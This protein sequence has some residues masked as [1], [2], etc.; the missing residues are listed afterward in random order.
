MLK[1]LLIGVLAVAIIASGSPA[2]ARIA[3]PVQRNTNHESRFIVLDSGTVHHWN[4][5]PWR[6]PCD[7]WHSGENDTVHTDLAVRQRHTR[8]LV[9]CVFNLLDPS[10]TQHALYIAN[11][12]SHFGPMAFNPSGCAGVFQHQ[13][14]YWTPRTLLIPARWLA[15]YVWTLWSYHGTP[16]IHTVSP[17]NA[18]A[19]VWV[20][21]F[22]VVGSGWGPWGG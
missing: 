17:F 11:R 22:M 7:G 18:Y 6:G 15:P 10:Q 19:N 21:A 13:E 20:T 3:K 1:R 5:G 8:N 12:E 4:P 14:S 9:V 16:D 2:Q